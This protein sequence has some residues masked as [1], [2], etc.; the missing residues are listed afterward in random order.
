MSAT[1]EETAAVAATEGKRMRRAFM[2]RMLA[3]SQWILENI[4]V[5]GKG[6]KNPTLGRMFGVVTSHARK[7]NKLPDGRDAESIVL[8]GVFE[9]VNNVT[10]EITNAGQA[11]LPMAFAE[12]V[13]AAFKIN[14]GTLAVEIDIDIGV[15]ATGKAIPYEWMVTSH[16]E[17]EQTL[18]LN[19]L[20]ERR[21]RPALPA[22]AEVKTIAHDDKGMDKAGKKA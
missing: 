2:P 5:K 22:P 1:Q 17:G 14:P 12:Q 16:L 10:G 4:V 21:V 3:D 20:R 13:E 7:V 6:F 15:E 19:R 18:F 9:V 11:Y 8:S